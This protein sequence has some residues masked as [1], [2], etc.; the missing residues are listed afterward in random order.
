MKSVAER[1]QFK[2]FPGS[3]HFW[4][5][6]QIAAL[7]PQTTAVLDIGAATGLIGK[8]L[9]EHGFRNLTAVEIDPAARAELQTTY[10]QV[11][12]SIDPLTNNRYDLILLL[13]VLEHL[14]RPRHFFLRR[15][16][17]Y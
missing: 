7:N 16:A 9:H 10:T 6:E 8:A 1:Y 11:E 12:A 4:V 5:L 3:S 15:S 2:P 17:N 14:P 13:D